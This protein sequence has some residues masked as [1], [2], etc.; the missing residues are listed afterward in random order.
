MSVLYFTAVCTVLYTLCASDVQ[1]LLWSLVLYTNPFYMTVNQVTTTLLWVYSPADPIVEDS[2]EIHGSDN[3]L[4]YAPNI[5]WEFIYTISYTPGIMTPYL[6]TEITRWLNFVWLCLFQYPI[7]HINHCDVTISVQQL[8]HLTLFR[9][10][11][12]DSAVDVGNGATSPHTVNRLPSKHTRG[13]TINVFKR[14]L[15]STTFWK[16]KHSDCKQKHQG[17]KTKW[18]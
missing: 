5:R 15:N 10:R 9:N 4:I 14:Y 8:A 16:F 18:W 3:A 17:T 12:E 11:K 7:F 1:L 2:N 6:S 13:C